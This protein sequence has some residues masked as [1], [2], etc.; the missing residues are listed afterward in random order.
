MLGAGLINAG[1]ILL[2]K[3]R[4]AD[5]GVIGVLRS[6]FLRKL[7]EPAIGLN[8][9]D[10]KVPEPGVVNEEPVL[11]RLSKPAAAMVAVAVAEA[12]SLCRR[13]WERAT[14]ESNE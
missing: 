9:S 7:G 10:G 2:R 8:S 11:A 13:L 1:D 3:S 6:S 12:I 5:G 14:E 4:Y